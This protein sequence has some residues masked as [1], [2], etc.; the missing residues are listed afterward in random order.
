MAAGLLPFHAATVRAEDL[1]AIYRVDRVVLLQPDFVLKERL[2]QPEALGQYIR[3]IN[4]SVAAAVSAD[5]GWRSGGFLVLA[6]RPGGRAR[7]WQDLAPAAAPSQV[8]ALRQAVAAVQPPAVTNGVVVFAIQ[9]GLHGGDSGDPA[10]MPA[11]PEW[12]T[13]AQE[14]PGHYEMGQL[15][16]LVW[17]ADSGVAPFVQ[18]PP[19]A[20]IPEGYELASLYPLKVRMLKPVDWVQD[21]HPTSSGWEWSFAKS[22]NDGSLYGTG[23]RLQLVSRL[24][25][26]GGPYPH[27]RARQIVEL[28]R[29]ASAHVIH[30]CPIDVNRDQAHT[31]LEV[32]EQSGKG[33]S[34]QQ[35]HV[36]Y[37]LTWSDVEDYLLLSIFGAPAAEWARYA[38][39]AERMS[40]FRQS[41]E[42]QL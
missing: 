37:T 36:R 5:S 9:V 15:A 35:F 3:R 14:H 6:V 8:E 7:L 13:Y 41:S 38:D 30:D 27:E 40:V 2:P 31:C 21:G 10:A 34:M 16:D 26:N 32:I 11:P 39:M 20:A 12:R 28:R 25:A 1:T 29:K 33:K 17:G 19:G 4:E 23:L 24:K 22:A 42:G 18:A